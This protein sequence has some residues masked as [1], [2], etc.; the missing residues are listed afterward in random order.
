MK[1]QICTVLSVLCLIALAGCGAGGGT[2][3]SSSS[4]ISGGKDSAG[5]ASATGGLSA[6]SGADS[7][8]NDSMPAGLSGADGLPETDT[9]GS[10]ASSG[11]DP[12]SSADSTLDP[13]KDTVVWQLRIVDGAE[14]GS[15]VLAGQNAGEVYSLSVNNIPVYLDGEPAD[16]AALEDG[17]MID[18]NFDGMIMETYPGQF[19]QVYEIHAYS[20]GTEQ[21]PGGTYFDLCGLYLQVLN[22]LWDKDP[23][24]NEN[25]LHI[26]LDLSQAPGN[27]TE[28]EKSAL[29]WIFA[30]QHGAN[31]LTLSHE[32]L[33]QQGYLSEVSG[34]GS[35]KLY[36]WEDGILFTVTPV[37]HEDMM[38]CCLCG[39]FHPATASAQ[40]KDAD[41]CSLPVL[42]FNVDKWRSPLGAYLFTDCF[43]YWPEAGTWSEYEVGSELIS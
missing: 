3:T 9:G 1:K 11:K 26:S 4:D 20:R 5:S 34:D 29:A 31:A 21:N 42:E 41:L 39:C 16:A 35:N 19:G 15:L 8:S 37:C 12:A 25:I 23:G 36:Q 40:W 30:G 7:L 33:V 28:G 17:M 2:Q 6:A 32:E 27:L 14:S 18:V 38:P 24:L 22:D 43:V 10:F 13:G